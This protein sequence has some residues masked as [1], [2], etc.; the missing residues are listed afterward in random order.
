[1]RSRLSFIFWLA[2]LLS[3]TWSYGQ[4]QCT[5]R[6][7][8]ARTRLNQG[9]LYE[10]ANILSPCLESGFTNEQ[11]IEAYRILTMVFLYLDYDQEADNNYL[12]LLKL[13]PEYEVNREFDPLELFLH[14]QKFTTKPKVILHLGKVGLNRVHY[15]TLL[16]YSITQ[17]NNNSKSIQSFSGIDLGL[18]IELAL[19][20]NFSLQLE[21]SFSRA[22]FRIFD[23]HYQLE[24]LPDYGFFSQFDQVYSFFDMP[25]MLKYTFADK[26][27]RPYLA[28][29]AAPSFMLS[30][31]GR[32]YEGSLVD[33]LLNVRSLDGAD[34]NLM[35]LRNNFNLQLSA[36]AGLQ[37]KIGVNYITLE[38]RYLSALRNFTNVKTRMD[39]QTIDDRRVKM[40]QHHIDDD[41]RLERFV[42]SVGFTKPIYQPRKIKK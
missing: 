28:L 12:N 38:I 39:F 29:G 20:K 27:L 26:S 22:G 17:D 3:N 19:Y 30:A 42:L 41:F 15:N 14:H 9:K 1:M 37:Y 11:K 4:D 33:S 32:R 6:L 21:G 8:Q 2:L 5:Q 34:I 23:A 7:E 35:N 40:P 18:G 36:A 16:E 10:I 31:A 25:V 24:N 13:S